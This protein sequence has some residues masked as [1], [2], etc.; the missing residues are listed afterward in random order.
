[1]LSIRGRKY[2]TLDLAE[3]YT[4]VRGNLYDKVKHPDGLVSLT[5]AENVRILS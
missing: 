2:A 1:M 5:M 3:G 4:K